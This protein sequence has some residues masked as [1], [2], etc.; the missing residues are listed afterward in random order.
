MRQTSCQ[1]FF[2]YRNRYYQQKIS[3][4]IY[5]FQYCRRDT[6]CK[7][8]VYNFYGF[9]R[10]WLFLLECICEYYREI[11]NYQSNACDFDIY[12]IDIC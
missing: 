10:F 12:S 8:F 11:D 7:I 6:S 9:L 1:Y 3:L 5:C 2:Q 4:T